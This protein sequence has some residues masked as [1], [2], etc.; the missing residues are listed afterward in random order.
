MNE[1]KKG[2][3]EWGLYIGRSIP[4]WCALPGRTY[5]PP[6]GRRDQR[7]HECRTQSLEEDCTLGESCSPRTVS[8][9]RQHC[10]AIPQSGRKTAHWSWGFYSLELL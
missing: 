2:L 5:M 6:L 1:S 10:E 9:K 7:V 4:E 8:N 3:V